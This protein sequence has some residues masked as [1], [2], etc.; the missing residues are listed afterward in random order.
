MGQ[1]WQT[2]RPLPIPL[3]SSVVFQQVDL[4][5]AF[6]QPRPRLSLIEMLWGC[7]GK[8]ATPLPKPLGSL[9]F[10]NETQ[11]CK[12]FRCGSEVIRGF[13]SKMGFGTKT[14]PFWTSTRQTHPANNLIFWWA[15]SF[16]HQQM[17][18]WGSFRGVV[19]WWRM[20]ND[21]EWTSAS[22]KRRSTFFWSNTHWPQN[23]TSMLHRN[24]LKAIIKLSN[25]MAP[26]NSQ[27]EQ[28]FSRTSFQIWNRKNFFTCF[29]WLTGAG[30][31][32][33]ISAR[34]TKNI[35]TLLLDQIWL[36]NA[37]R[38]LFSNFCVYTEP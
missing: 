28:F 2:G 19:K 14:D 26:P 35:T 15:R 8:V 36:R 6:C 11:K 22:V 24:F 9:C 16:F 7:I 33:K 3:G 1:S 12:F 4:R 32:E 25:K 5:A 20:M 29:Y 13:P 17:H 30:P 27:P 34:E 38:A 18:F 37:R 10:L 23:A 21:D 31:A